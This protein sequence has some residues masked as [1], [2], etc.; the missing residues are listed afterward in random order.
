MPLKPWTDRRIRP[1]RRLDTVK[2]LDT[3]LSVAGVFRSSL[4]LVLGAL[5]Q[6]AA[7]SAPDQQA[8]SNPCQRI[9]FRYSERI[10]SQGFLG[11]LTPDASTE[12]VASA[13]RREIEEGWH[14]YRGEG[15]PRPVPYYRPSETPIRLSE[16]CELATRCGKRTLSFACVGD[17]EIASGTGMRTVLIPVHRE[18]NGEWVRVFPADA[19]SEWESFDWREARL[20]GRC[21]ISTSASD[22]WDEVVASRWNRADESTYVGDFD[23]EGD[24]YN[25]L[26]EPLIRRQVYRKLI[27]DAVGEAVESGCPGERR[28]GSRGPGPGPDIT[29]DP[30]CAPPQPPDPLDVFWAQEA[31]KEADRPP[32]PGHPFKW[33]DLWN[34][35]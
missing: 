4:L 11:T 7:A 15:P 10:E 29:V 35:F 23:K 22:D 28:P 14:L 31:A 9:Q 26:D 32:G 24:R 5:P 8:S 17:T 27:H 12:P 34:L 16:L 3:R 21:F 6:P 19:P 13:L 25:A 30:S 1:H 18:V 33:S 2:V 20:L